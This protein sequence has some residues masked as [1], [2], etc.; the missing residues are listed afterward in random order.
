MPANGKYIHLTVLRRLL[1]MG[2]VTVVNEKILTY[3]FYSGQGDTFTSATEN[4]QALETKGNKK[5]STSRLAVLQTI[6]GGFDM[7]GRNNFC[8]FALIA[9]LSPTACF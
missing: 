6:S 5:H 7:R 3:Q 4:T 2:R 8:Y 1:N 9:P